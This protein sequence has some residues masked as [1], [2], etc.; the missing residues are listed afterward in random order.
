MHTLVG[1][2]VSPWSEK[3]R[4][5]LDHHHI[6]F[7][8]EEYVPLLGE[9]ALRLKMRKVFGKVCVPVLFHE[10][11]A[12]GESIEIA[13]F[14]EKNGS[15]KAL[16]GVDRESQ[17]AAWNERSDALLR[18]GR[19][20]VVFRTSDD[21]QAKEEALPSFIPGALK[22][23]LSPVA[24]IGCEYL[25][26][27]YGTT[28]ATTFDHESAMRDALD[29]LRRGLEGGKSYLL[30]DFSFADVAMAAALQ[31][32][33]PVSDAY[34]P[35]GPATRDVWTHA[36]LARAYPDLLAW[37]DAIYAKHRRS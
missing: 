26:M 32:V 35:I 37:R 13:R 5:A 10:K 12:T 9:P 2:S 20:L 3:A 17:V 22:P 8:F 15:G 36:E 21:E 29:A 6:P 24:K 23:M 27:K 19:A 25:K 4:W 7:T 31:A 18:G 14:A 16:F 30:G 33:S 28:A 11:Q 1:L 34:W